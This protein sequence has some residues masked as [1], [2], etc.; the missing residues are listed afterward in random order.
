MYGIP[1]Y[2][3]ITLKRFSAAIMMYYTVQHYMI[4]VSLLFH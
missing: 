2:C 1:T 3:D 4:I